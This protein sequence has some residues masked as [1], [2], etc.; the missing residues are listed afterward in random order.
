MKRY[1]KEFR[2]ADIERIR[3]GE[4][5]STVAKDLGISSKTLNS[6]WRSTKDDLSPKELSDAEEIIWLRRLLREKKSEINFLKKASAY[7]A[8]LS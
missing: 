3:N 6:W 8:K 1:S 4:T 5:Q 2:Q 7:F